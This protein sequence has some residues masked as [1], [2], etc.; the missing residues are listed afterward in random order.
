MDT[1]DDNIDQFMEA[2]EKDHDQNQDTVCSA[3]GHDDQVQLFN[4]RIPINQISI[5]LNVFRIQ[6][7]L[8]ILNK[9]S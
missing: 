8:C 7:E 3:T 1:T 6:K 5:T 4:D 2:I 9:K